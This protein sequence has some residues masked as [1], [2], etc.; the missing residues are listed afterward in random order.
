MTI[1]FLIKNYNFNDIEII[2]VKL[3]DNKLV[4]DFNINA[5][6]DLIANGYRPELDMN[7][8]QTFVFE[9][10]NIKLN[11]KKTYRFNIIKEDCYYILLNENKIKIISNN[12]EVYMD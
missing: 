9:I 6:L 7:V 3:N 12:V 8:N 4:V 5:H 10:E 11:I 2:N 1:D